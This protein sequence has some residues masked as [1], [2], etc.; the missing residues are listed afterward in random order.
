MTYPEICQFCQQR[1]KELGISQYEMARLTGI[2][3][4]NIVLFEKGEQEMKL[5]K[6]MKYLE[7]LGMTISFE[8]IKQ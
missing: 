1:R 8:V 2:A 7:A 6:F 5:P 3:R 4:N